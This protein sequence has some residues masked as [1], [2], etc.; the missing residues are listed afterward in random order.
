MHKTGAVD[1]VKRLEDNTTLSD[2]WRVQ[3]RIPGVGE[4]GMRTNNHLATWEALTLFRSQVLVR[5]DCGS[6][7]AKR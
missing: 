1:S 6:M 5:N 7:A 2:T 4:P 3:R